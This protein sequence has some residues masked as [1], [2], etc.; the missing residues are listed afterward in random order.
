[1]DQCLVDVTRVPDRVA[2]GDDAVLVGTQGDEE[3][4][5]EELA[6]RLETIAY[7]VLTGISARVPRQTVGAVTP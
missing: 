2:I 7:E 3:I 1:M 4:S 6:V 5:A